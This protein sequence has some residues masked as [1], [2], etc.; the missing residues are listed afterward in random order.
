MGDDGWKEE[1]RKYSGWEFTVA[2]IYTI[3]RGHVEEGEG[4]LN[5]DTSGWGLGFHVLDLGFFRYDE[6]TSVPVDN[7]SGVRRRGWT[8]GVD[9]LATWHRL[10]G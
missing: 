6:S 4:G 10:R 3:R 1:E 2:N 9:L 7:R 5:G 8:F